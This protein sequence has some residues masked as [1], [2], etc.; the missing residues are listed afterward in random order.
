MNGLYNVLVTEST[1]HMTL[2]E[3]LVVF[4]TE[5]YQIGHLIDSLFKIDV[6]KN[7]FRYYWIDNSTVNFWI[8]SVFVRYFL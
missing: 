8:R 1:Y 5:I 2:Y 4:E 7:D 6:F 3:R